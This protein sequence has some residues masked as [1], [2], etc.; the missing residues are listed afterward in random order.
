MAKP[1]GKAIWQSHVAAAAPL[2]IGYI[3]C[4]GKFLILRNSMSEIHGD[5]FNACA[6]AQTLGDG[7]MELGLIGLSR[8]HGIWDPTNM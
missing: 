2:W 7:H 1:Y 5:V 4:F 3:M 6:H 8:T